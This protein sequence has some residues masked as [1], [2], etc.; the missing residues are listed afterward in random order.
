MSVEG[1]GENHLCNIHKD[2]EC[3]GFGLLGL[4]ILVYFMGDTTVLQF[5]LYI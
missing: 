2:K 3:E 1:E 5:C 4:K